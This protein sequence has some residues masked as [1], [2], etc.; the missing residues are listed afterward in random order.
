[1]ADS[2]E[3]IE[4]PDDAEDCF[5][6]IIEK[7]RVKL[8]HIPAPQLAGRGTSGA[9]PV[10]VVV[11]PVPKIPRVNFTEEEKKERKNNRARDKY[12]EAAQKAA[13]IAELRT[14]SNTKQTEDRSENAI[15]GSARRQLLH[16]ISLFKQL[17]EKELKSFKINR[18]ADDDVLQQY[19][20]EMSDIVSIQSIDGFVVAGVLKVMADVEPFS[21]LT[22]Y[23]LTGLSER[24]RTDESFNVLIKKIYIKRCGF[25][26]NLPDEV[27]LLLIMIG[28][29]AT[30]VA[31][32]NSNKAQRVVAPQLATKP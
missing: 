3:E 15:I 5:E 2:D 17:F 6:S 23:D 28:Q 20:N 16:K 10:K 12:A 7:H 14:K 26:S 29:A 8:G 27:N 31:T 11:P 22:K 25:L 19:I 24:L 13:N 21:R 1:M 32:N 4:I 30:T 9:P 18:N